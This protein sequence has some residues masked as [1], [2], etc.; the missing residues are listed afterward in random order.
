VLVIG[1]T[2]LAILLLLPTVV[3][4]LPSWL[5][6]MKGSKVSLGLDLQGGTHL[7][8]QVDTDQA[9]VNSLEIS[10]DEMRRELRKESVRAP[11]IERVAD[12]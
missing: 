12:G 4:P 10:S 2:L 7:I 6:F 3:Q 1:L 11:K 9:V 5:S 8:M